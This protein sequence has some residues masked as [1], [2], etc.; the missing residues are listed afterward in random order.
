MD[1][2]QILVETTK[3]RSLQQQLQR[4]VDSFTSSGSAKEEVELDAPLGAAE[5][6][7]LVDQFRRVR[8]FFWPPEQAPSDQ[9]VSRTWREF[10]KRALT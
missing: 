8:K 9:L 10:H 2:T 3:L 4:Q 6:A 7:G 5:L 1:P